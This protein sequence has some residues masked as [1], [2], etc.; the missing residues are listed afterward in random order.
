MSIEQHT[1]ASSGSEDRSHREEPARGSGPRIVIATRSV[2]EDLYEKASAF[3]PAHIE[4]KRITGMD[5]WRDALTYL[6][7][8]LRIDADFV[9][10]CDED[11]FIYDWGVVE[12]LIADMA[13]SG[14]CYAG[15]GD[16][17]DNC[18]HRNNSAD[19]HNPF[20]N[21]FAPKKVRDMLL[22]TP[23]Y[24]NAVLLGSN[25][26][27]CSYHEIFNNFFVALLP[28]PG[29]QLLGA[30]HRDGISTELS[31]GRK[32]FALHSWWSREWRNDGPHYYR[33]MALYKEAVQRARDRE[34]QNG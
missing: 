27:G 29:V 9:V 18:H 13:A 31:Y 23:W 34:H 28:H 8:L 32:D 6:H 10:N 22:G 33:I 14:I 20:F 17:V 26:P 4:R 30:D 25:P 16:T 24:A 12:E 3:W 21:V 15:M 11:C 5:D 19:V 2:H 1:S 7:E